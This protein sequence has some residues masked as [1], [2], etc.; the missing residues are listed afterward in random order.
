MTE[1]DGKIVV[2]GKISRDLPGSPICLDHI[3]AIE[4]DRIVS[5]EIRA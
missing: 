1:R 2:I 5:L 3:F 4:G